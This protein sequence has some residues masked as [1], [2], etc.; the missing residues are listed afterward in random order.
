MLKLQ[1]SYNKLK[2]EIKTYSMTDEEK[3]LAK[4][5]KLEEE[6]T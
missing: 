6:K 2:D 3:E 5:T 1:E 4:L